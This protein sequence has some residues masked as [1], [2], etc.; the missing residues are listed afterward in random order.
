M[1]RLFAV[2]AAAFAGTFVLEGCK[3]AAAK[4]LFKL[5]DDYISKFEDL[6]KNRHAKDQC[7]SLWMEAKAKVDEIKGAK[8]TKGDKKKLNEKVDRVNSLYSECVEAV[9]VLLE[10]CINEETKEVFKLFDEHITKF[11]D[12]NK[13]D[14]TRSQC[15]SL[16]NELDEKWNPLQGK[17]K[18]TDNDEKQLQEKYGKVYSLAKKCHDTSK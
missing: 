3:N 2:I 1:F 13:Q 6:N 7:D 4:D 17:M 9:A 18:G 16:G 5:V 15:L 12:L 10:G 14:H 8:G 11:E